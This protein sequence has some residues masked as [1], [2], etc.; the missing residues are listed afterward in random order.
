M[1]AKPQVILRRK[2]QTERVYLLM[3]PTIL[4]Y[5]LDRGYMLLVR[6]VH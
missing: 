5:P 3:K 4:T 2:I 6:L 1:T